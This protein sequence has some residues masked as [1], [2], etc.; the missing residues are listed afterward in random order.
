MR[1]PARLIKFSRTPPSIRSLIQ[2]QNRLFRPLHQRLAVGQ[3]AVDVGAAPE[4][5][6]E[7]DLDRVVELVRQI[8]DI[9]IKHHHLRFD[10]GERCEH[11]GKDAGV[12][13][14]GRH[15]AGLVYAENDV[16]QRAALAFASRCVSRAR[17]CC[18]P[19]DSGEGSRGS[20]GSSRSRC[21]GAGGCGSRG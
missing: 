18:T 14:A 6:A 2:H 11:G 12:D 1:E 7:Q 20:S 13:D 16:A 8:H 4:L 3:R 5:G 19:A 10:R 9:G 21:A 17:S 15:R